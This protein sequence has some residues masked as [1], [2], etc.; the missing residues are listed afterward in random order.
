MN[1]VTDLFCSLVDTALFLGK[2]RRVIEPSSGGSSL[3]H[4]SVDKPLVASR[5]IS[6]SVIKA[7]SN[8]AMTVQ[9]HQPHIFVTQ[10]TDDKYILSAVLPYTDSL[11]SFVSQ[12][13]S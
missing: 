1:S 3:Y 4:I 13:C 7:T 8:S 9:R 2:V 6:Q 10:R 11:E 12:L 5:P